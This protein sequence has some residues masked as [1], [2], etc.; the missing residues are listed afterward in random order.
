MNDN[1]K[2]WVQ[3]LRSGE[4]KKGRWALR[5]QDKGRDKFC[6][7]GVA[8]D[9]YQ[10]Q[11]GGLFV[12]TKGGLSYYDSRASDLP[13]R[14]KDWLGLADSMGSFQSGK[15]SLMMLNDRKGYDFVQIAKVIESEPSLFSV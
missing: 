8:C 7:L 6:C 12:E 11:V 10:Q 4:Y 15:N 5:R 9:L 2:L 13:D 14:V 1:A 3:A